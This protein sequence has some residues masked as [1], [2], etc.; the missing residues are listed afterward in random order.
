MKV[1]ELIEIINSHSNELPSLYFLE[2]HDYE[3]EL[4]LP[5]LIAR[6]EGKIHRW[7]TEATDVY[8]CEDGYVGVTG[9]DY[10]HEDNVESRD[11]NC[12]CHAEEY[13]AVPSITYKPKVANG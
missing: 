11:C 1:K 13:E 10:N 3:F 5:K 8:E 6:Y 2:N 7:F 4:E 12:Y 9:F